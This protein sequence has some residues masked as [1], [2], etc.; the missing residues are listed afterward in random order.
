MEHHELTFRVFVSSMFSDLKAER[1]VMQ[2]DVFPCPSEYCQEHGA[3]FQA[4]DLRWG[5]PEKGADGELANSWE[6]CRQW[7]DRVEPFFVCILGQRYGWVPEP[8]HFRDNADK[9]RQ[10]HEP[11]SITDLEVRHAVLDQPQFVTES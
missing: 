8:H 4:I 10:K 3:R 11:R 9:Q 2:R 1:D 6:Y 7:I 5:V